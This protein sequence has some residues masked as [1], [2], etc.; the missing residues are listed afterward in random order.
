M[1]LVLH[2]GFPKTGTSSIQAYCTQNQEA[3]KA[4]GTLYAKT[5]RVLWFKERER[6]VGLAMAFRP[7]HM[8]PTGLMRS[9]G[10]VRAR[11]RRRFTQKFLRDLD[12]EI[13]RSPGVHTVIL[14]DEAL[15]GFPDR[16]IPQ[17]LHD[18]MTQRFDQVSVL[19]MVR[20]PVGYLTSNYAQEVKMG[21]TRLWPE[22]LQA[23]LAHNFFLDKIQGWQE[24]FGAENVLVR[25]LKQDAVADFGEALDLPG[26]LRDV[27]R[28]NPS[29]SRQGIELLR[30]VNA[31]YEAQGKKRPGSVR[32]AFVAH[33]TGA[34]RKAS[35]AETERIY[36]ARA[37]EIASLI[38]SCNLPEADIAH[39]RAQW[40]PR[41]N[42]PEQAPDE[43]EKLAAM[44][45]TLFR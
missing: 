31:A 30:V 34:G 26:G 21:G 32:K 22:F 40:R 25:V 35:V 15:G 28:A 16:A 2:V 9:Y 23:M 8:A 24:I 1:R 29:L 43:S 36:A 10:L 11:A 42:E 19:C 12:R 33:M 17:L 18:E 41:T 13:A 3:L 39:I 44:L 7:P 38:D 27:A 4:Q 6:H 14:S 20:D 45:T 37:E 5:G